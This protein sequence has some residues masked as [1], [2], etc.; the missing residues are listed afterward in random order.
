MG[1]K[2]EI[3]GNGT[4]EPD[5]AICTVL[6]FPSTPHPKVPLVSH[7]LALPA[8]IIADIN[9][10]LPKDEFE[11]PISGWW[12]WLG[13]WTSQTNQELS[14][15]I[16]II[17]K[18]HHWYKNHHSFGS[19]LLISTPFDLDYNEKNPSYRRCFRR[20][21]YFALQEPPNR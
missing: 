11:A 1:R 4:D 10:S 12:W 19:A 2:G 6:H 13:D 18:D 8:P 20:L 21:G 14:I 16:T 7:L 17:E 9:W 15:T 3:K 5:P